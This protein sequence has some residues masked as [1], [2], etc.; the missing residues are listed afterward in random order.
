MKETALKLRVVLWD[1]ADIA[2]FILKLAPHL[3]SSGFLMSD[4][5]TG[6]WIDER[7]R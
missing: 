6:A 1:K 5:R 4:E 2:P 7:E 3:L